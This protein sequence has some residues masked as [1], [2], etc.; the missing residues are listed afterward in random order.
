LNQLGF[1]DR[2]VYAI[3]G[4]VA[5]IREHLAALVAPVALAV[6]AFTKFPAFGAAI[7]ASHCEISC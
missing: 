2:Q 4:G 5:G 7:V 1:L 3:Q 6:L